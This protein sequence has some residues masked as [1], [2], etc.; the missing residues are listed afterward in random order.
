LHILSSKLLNFLISHPSSDH[1][2]GSRLMNALNINSSHLPT[3]FSSLANLTTYTI[4]WVQP[5]RRTRSS[6][7][8]TLAQPS[9][10]QITK[11]S[12]RY[13]LPF[14]WNQLPSSFRQPH[15][16]HSP[17]VVHFLLCISPHHSHHLRCRHL[18]LAR[19]FAPVLKSFTNPFL[20]SLSDFFWTAFTDLYLSNEM[21]TGVCLF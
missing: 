8:A 18:S 9:V 1:C 7:A 2:T 20:H 17:F 10:I 14:P 13:A 15:S 19:P 4:G 3:K 11:H 16:V 5:T 6:S 12:F 21:G